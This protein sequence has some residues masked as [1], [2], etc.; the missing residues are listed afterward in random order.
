MDVLKV[1]CKK[2]VNKKRTYLRHTPIFAM[3]QNWYIIADF[4][5]LSRFTP[6]EFNLCAQILH[7]LNH[8]VWCTF[9]T[10]FETIELFIL[11][12]DI[13]AIIYQS[14]GL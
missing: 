10:K 4:L 8:E 12:L 6:S 3:T 1:C 5:T 7:G 9:I 2:I 13:S 11:F 14:I